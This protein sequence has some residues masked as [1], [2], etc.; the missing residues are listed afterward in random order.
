M[1]TAVKHF[2]IKM[3]NRAR[4]RKCPV[5]QKP[6]TARE[7]RTS[8]RNLNRHLICWQCR[9]NDPNAS[10]EFYGAKQRRPASVFRKQFWA[11]NGLLKKKLTKKEVMNLSAKQIKQQSAQFLRFPERVAAI[12]GKTYS[13]RGD[14]FTLSDD[15]AMARIRD[16]LDEL[17]ETLVERN[18][19]KRLSR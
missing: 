8:N 3:P 19:N 18:K 7:F 2:G 12:V 9:H 11:I 15:E 13:I 16:L 10:V 1:T 4:Y 17:D 14:D 5:C 6:R